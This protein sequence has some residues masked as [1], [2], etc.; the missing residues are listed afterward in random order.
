MPTGVLMWICIILIATCLCVRPGP[1]PILLAFV[2]VVLRQELIRRK[3][4][5]LRDAHLFILEWMRES[6]DMRLRQLKRELERCRLSSE[7]SD[8][9]S[10]EG[11]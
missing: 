8:T 3:V 11:A 10:R 2:F 6:E 9:D 5:Q 1:G 7:D 4:V